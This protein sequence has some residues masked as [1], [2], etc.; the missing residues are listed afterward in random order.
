MATV[1]TIINRSLRLIG[2]LNSGES[3]TAQELADG[4]E[5]L[6][7]M[8]SSWRNEKLM[9]YAIRDESITISSGNASR[10]I[11]ATGNLVTDR[12]VRIESAYIVYQNSSIPMIQMSA[13][14]FAAISYPSA[15]A[16]YPNY[17]YYRPEFPDGKVLLYPVAN[18]SSVMHILTWTPVT[19]FA[20]VGTTVTL[21]PGWDDALSSN[22]ALHIAPEYEVEPSNTLLGMAR[23]SK[24]AIKKINSKPI[25]LYTEIPLLT[26]GSHSNIL[27]GDWN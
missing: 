20:A 26:G 27:T 15:T 6:N 3:G 24:S 17:F 9:C 22:L 16:T 1:T 11:G 23:N 5:A 10:T 2:Q 21:P 4:L 18:A 8:L 12:P 13:A 14:E 25:K 19:A 7:Y